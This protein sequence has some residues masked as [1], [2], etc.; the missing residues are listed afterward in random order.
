MRDNNAD[1]AVDTAITRMDAVRAEARRT[2]IIAECAED[3]ACAARILAKDI[4]RSIAD[5]T[6]EN[7]SLQAAVNAAADRAT[8]IAAAA[9][10]HYVVAAYKLRT[11]TQSSNKT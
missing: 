3:N 4:S 10:K 2:G 9:A 6:A 1:K 7:E 8:T 11:L 5:A